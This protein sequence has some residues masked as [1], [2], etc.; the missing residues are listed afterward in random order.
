MQGRCIVIGVGNPDRGDDAVG[1][2]VAEHLRDRIGKTVEVLEHDGEVTALLE[3]LEHANAVYLI[4]AACSGKE[5]GTIQRFDAR[6]GPLPRTIFTM[7]THGFG[8]VEA[9]ELA[10]A[11]NILPDTCVIY[12]IE[13]ASF[14]AGHS[15][16]DSVARAA[17]S[18]TEQ[19]LAELA[20]RD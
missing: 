8:P 11:M 3:W 1:R 10:R 14:E 6:A 4:D 2:V 20:N 18:A 7:S 19:V 15:L 5:P 9:V 17:R 16:S 13:G 12:A